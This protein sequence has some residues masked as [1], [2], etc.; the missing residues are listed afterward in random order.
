MHRPPLP[1]EDTPGTHSRATV[2][3]EEWSQW[4]IQ[5]YLSGIEPVIC[6]LVAQ[7][8]NQLRQGLFHFHKDCIY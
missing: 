7:Y 3:Q 8:L 4:I 2:R 6:W 5:M 1:L